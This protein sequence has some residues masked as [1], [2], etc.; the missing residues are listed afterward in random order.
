[1]A[2]V[3]LA[4]IACVQKKFDTSSFGALVTA[5]ERSTKVVSMQVTNAEIATV[6]QFDLTMP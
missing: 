1:M 6:E 3:T 2:A 4:A 5:I